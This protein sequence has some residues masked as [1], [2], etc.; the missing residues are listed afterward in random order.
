M[1]DLPE[2]LISIEA[3]SVVRASNITSQQELNR[4]L[5]VE[6]TDSS[7]MTSGQSSNSG[8]H[9][10]FEFLNIRPVKFMNIFLEVLRVLST[11]KLICLCLDDLH[12]ADEESLGLISNIMARKFR[13][14]LIVS[15]L[16]AN[17]RT[18]D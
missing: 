18:D 9:T 11:N 17:T 5:R 6:T 14:A 13:I 1:L 7:S 4:S 15:I 16:F 3:H 12:N 8:T 10:T 2:N